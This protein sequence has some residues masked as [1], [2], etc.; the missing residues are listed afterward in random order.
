MVGF[1]VLLKVA[2]PALQL[3]NPRKVSRAAGR[4]Y[5]TCTWSYSD[6]VV[7]NA[8]RLTR[9]ASRAPPDPVG[10]HE[11][12]RARLVAA[13]PIKPNRADPW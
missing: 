11:E 2:G 10:T 9:S 5:S 12:L 8:H 4:I 3:A 13:A 6:M 7:R 1:C